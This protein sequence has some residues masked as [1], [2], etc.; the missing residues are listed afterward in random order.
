MVV[1]DLFIKALSQAV[2]YQIRE[3]P[4]TEVSAAITYNLQELWSNYL[5]YFNCSIGCVEHRLT[6]APSR[7][8]LRAVLA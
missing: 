1:I 2:M 6:K 5:F 4:N 8:V 3:C 7:G